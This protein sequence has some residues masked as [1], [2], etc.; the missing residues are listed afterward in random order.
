M[1][2]FLNHEG[3]RNASI[4]SELVSHSRLG[5][6]ANNW[7]W[8]SPSPVWVPR[9]C[10]TQQ[11]ASL[12]MAAA[13]SL[14]RSR[15]I[16]GRAAQAM[17]PRCQHLAVL[18]KPQPWKPYGPLMQAPGLF[19][20]MQHFCLP[21]KSN[22]TEPTASL[23]PGLER[24]IFEGGGL[25]STSKKKK[26]GSLSLEGIEKRLG[27][28]PNVHAGKAGLLQPGSLNPGAQFRSWDTPLPAY[29]ELATNSMKNTSPW[30]S[31]KP[32]NGGFMV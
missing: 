15:G 18:P 1:H 20:K 5:I 24:R 31:I 10:H 9:L 12:F 22:H 7:V 25:T 17:V 21:R 32:S 14:S 30:S 8:T 11:S 28:F 29:A 27:S 23:T 2:L 13:P 26:L 16:W 4:L 6:P 3:S 19:Q